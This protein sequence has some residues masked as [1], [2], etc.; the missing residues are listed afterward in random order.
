MDE[1]AGPE[2]LDGRPD[3]G[4]NGKRKVFTYNE[5]FLDVLIQVLSSLDQLKNI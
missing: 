1:L 2:A 5:S 4:K 3:K